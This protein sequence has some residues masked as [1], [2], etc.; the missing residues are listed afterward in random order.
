MRSTAIFTALVLCFCFMTSTVVAQ[1]VVF[2]PELHSG[3]KQ[4]TADGN[5]L[6]Q[7]CGFGFIGGIDNV[8][9]EDNITSCKTGNGGVMTPFNNA[10]SYFLNHQLFLASVPGN[11]RRLDFGGEW[12][13]SKFPFVTLSMPCDGRREMFTHWRDN[14]GN[15]GKYDDNPFAYKDP[16]TGQSVKIKASPV[17]NPTWGEMIGPKYTVRVVVTGTTKPLKLYFVDHPGI[18]VRNVEFSFVGGAPVGAKANIVGYVEVSNT[19]P[20]VFGGGGGGNGQPTLVFEAEGSAFHQTGNASGIGWLATVLDPKN[21]YL[22]YGPYT[23]GVSPGDRTATFRLKIDNNTAD[24]LAILEIDVFDSAS[25]TVLAKKTIKRKDFN[26]ANKYQEF[27]LSF[28]APAGGNL[29]FRVFYKG[30]AAVT[31]DKVIV[32]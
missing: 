8:D 5:K 9:D 18:S 23:K 32:S 6:L 31:H 17:S 10:G 24:N 16:L 3:I 14:G 7:G 2:S 11:S 28:S 19:D 13:V 30:Y 21:K 4:I 20:G 25:G 1:S 27:P 29:E 22:T 26:G 15:I 12:G